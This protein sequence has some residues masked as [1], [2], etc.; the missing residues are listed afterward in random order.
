MVLKAVEV[1][2]EVNL[3]V[4]KETSGFIK[5]NLP[6]D[7]VDY[8]IRL[9][10]ANAVYF[11]GAWE[12][13]FD[14]SNTK[15][16]N[17]FLL[18][19][20]S[21]QVPFMTSKEKQYILSVASS[22]FKVLKL[23]YEQDAKDGLLAIVEKKGS[24]SGFIEKHLPHYPVEVHEFLNPK[25]KIS[26]GFQVSEVLQELGLVFPFSGD[27][28]TEMVDQKLNISSIYHK[29]F[30]E[31]NEKGTKAAAASA[32]IVNL[33][34]ARHRKFDFVANHPFMFVVREDKTGV[35]LFIGQVHNPLSD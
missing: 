2:K 35:L 14:A 31:E 9:I 29:S 7:S 32:A 5:D 34:S 11:K 22:G 19:G 33:R 18:N 30:I 28:L 23:P 26:L 17:F 4:E 16:D 27:R 10:F 20:S 24:E 6:S 21:V 12:H 1:T 13:K 25:F 15:D 3:W 8:F